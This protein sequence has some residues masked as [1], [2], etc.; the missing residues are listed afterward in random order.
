MP[1]L[2]KWG[3]GRHPDHPVVTEAYD[4]YLITEEGN[5]I[6][7]AA[8]GAAVVNLGHSPD[9]IADVLFKQ[10]NQVGYTSTAYFT[11]PAIESLGE[12][13]EQITPGDLNTAF[14]ANSG[15]EA[16]ESAIKLA[17][18]YHVA[19]GEPARETVI[20]RW[21]SYH[22]ATL[23][24][25]SAS[26]NTGRRTIYKPL[27]RD[28][29]KIGP[30]YP[31]RW[32]YQG[33][34]E[35]QAEAAAGELERLILQEG[36][37]TV[38]AFIAEPVS[39]SSIP[40]AHPHPRYYKEVRRICNKYGVLFIAD[41]VMVG[42]GRTGEHFACE[43]YDVVP[44]MLTLGKGMSAG[45]APISATMIRDHIIETIEDV[46]QPF[47]H[48]HTFSANPIST[49]VADCVVDRYT[50]ELLEIVR[51]RGETLFEELEPLTMSAI[52]G[53]IRQLGLMIG[54]EFVADKET[55]QP[56][57]PDEEVSNQ[58][59]NQTLEKGVYTYPGGGSVDGHRGD[60]IMIAPPL[61][62]N[63]DG[64]EQIGNA[65]RDSVNEV[66]TALR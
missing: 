6:L 58:V 21:Q 26:G 15:S 51:K 5:K 12:K 28:W 24:A 56:F 41:E 33:T 13:L 32:P 60:H 39:G 7:D 44:D 23:G 53:E 25:L 59:F 18:D 8:A 61:T 49:A 2:Y 35:E 29:P 52:V 1:M 45:F 64:I 30:A 66:E 9:D 31:Y 10:A 4:E 38:A 46:N 63:E 55:K 54:I 42:F 17:R 43:H 65:V 40:V 16:N 11:S 3:A 48:G 62:I 36:P 34:P 20:G 47:Y 27:M 14:L 19:H 50:E 57:D 22:G 37:E